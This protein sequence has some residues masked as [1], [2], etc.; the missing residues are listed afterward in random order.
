MYHKRRRLTAIGAAVAAVLAVPGLAW[1]G[2]N[3]PSGGLVYAGVPQSFYYTTMYDYWSVIAVQPNFGDNYSLYLLTVGGGYLDLS[4]YGADDTNFVA[5]DSNSGTEPYAM[6]YGQVNSVV[7]GSYWI[8]AQYGQNAISI[9][10]PTHQGTTGFSDPD[11]TYSDLNDNNIVSIS[12]IYLS[13]GESF[14]AV[15]PDAAQMM[16]LLEATPG[17]SSTYIQSRAQA[18]SIQ[19]TKVIDNCTLYT[20]KQTG[21][22]ALVK[23]NDVPP[24][25]NA[26]QGEAV[27]IH[28]YDPNYPN[29]CPLAD[30]PSATPG[31]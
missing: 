10:T 22:H 13:A 9:P 12:D 17:Q 6:Y 8:Q 24:T 20:A 1:A 26:N 3:L 5:V 30:F 25:G 16:Y 7:P 18:S 29:Y 14:W 2:G 27:G 23:V 15:S 11:I 31:P 21:W 4:N 28:A 19:E